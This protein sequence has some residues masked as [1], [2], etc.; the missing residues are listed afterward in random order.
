MLKT[1][2]HGNEKLTQLTYLLIA[3]GLITTLFELAYTEAPFAPRV[4]I[5]VF[6]LITLTMFLFHKTSFMVSFLISTFTLLV[7]WRLATLMDLMT[8][9]Y[10]FLFAFILKLSNYVLCAYYDIQETDQYRDPLAHATRF[11]WQLF[12]IRMYAG[13]DLVPHF[14]EKL[15]AGP[16]SRA[17]D[18][19][20][21]VTYGVPHADFFVWL[22][23]F[24]EFGGA[25]ALSLGLFTR[26]GAIC[27]AIYLFV[28]TY[29]G[30]H[31]FNTFIWVSPGG[32]W[33]FPVFWAVLI[34]S[35]AFFGAGNFSLDRVI[36]DN[37]KLPMWIK[38][39]M[40]GRH[41]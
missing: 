15:F 5:I 39:L 36:K 10:I 18:I 9:V 37:M 14:T 12:F 20:A 29:L 26:L 25:I 3:V 34:L 35:F 28:A 17:D 33:E 30:Q 38:H 13:F 31:F 40:G 6:T 19:T 2:F 1:R 23:G 4:N 8:T 41:Y 11:E 24:C 32:G 22:A 21:F 16:G 7:A 27:L